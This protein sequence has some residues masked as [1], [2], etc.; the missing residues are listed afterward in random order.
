MNDVFRLAAVSGFVHT[1]MGVGNQRPREDRNNSNP[2]DDGTLDF[3]RHQE[4]DE[5]ATKSDANPHLNIKGLVSL[6]I[7]II[8]EVIFLPQDSP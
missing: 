8:G 7:R 4:G 2:N 5:D 1:N 3:E 6:R